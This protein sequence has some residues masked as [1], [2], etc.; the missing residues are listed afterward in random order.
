MHSCRQNDTLAVGDLVL[1][2]QEVGDDEHLDRVAGLRFAEGRATQ[3]ILAVRRQAHAFQ[4]QYA[5]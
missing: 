5:V 2:G 3:P 4:E 1:R